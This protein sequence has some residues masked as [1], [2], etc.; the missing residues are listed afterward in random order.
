M[1]LED[2]RCL[3]IVFA[4]H[5]IE[6]RSLGGGENKV[7]FEYAGFLKRDQIGFGRYKRENQNGGM[8]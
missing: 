7:P 6:A 8:T 3:V 4:L 1:K 2:I 5:R